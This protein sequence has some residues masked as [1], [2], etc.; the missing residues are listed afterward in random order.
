MKFEGIILFNS[1]ISFKNVG[2]QPVEEISVD[3]IQSTWEK[4]KLKFGFNKNV[5]EEIQSNFY[6]AIGYY[7]ELKKVNIK[8]R[9]GHIKTT[10]QCRPR[11]D[12]LFHSKENRSYVIYIDDKIENDNGILYHDMPL[13]AQIGVIG[14]E[15]AHIIDYRTMSNAQMIRFGIDYLKSRKKKEIENRVDL[16][17]IHSGLGHQIKDFS[18]YV[19]EDSGASLKYLSYKMKYYFKPSQINEF[20][21]LSPIYSY[22]QDVLKD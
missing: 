20:I 9:Y 7:P 5:P 2:I 22:V 17:A 6:T 4:L 12:F 16:I 1:C 13:N 21:A 8:V 19:F 10:M 18:Q 11:W 3:A 15:L 14:H